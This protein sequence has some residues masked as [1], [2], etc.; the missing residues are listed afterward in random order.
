V[1]YGCG[2]TAPEEWTN[3]DVSPTLRIQK[4]RILKFI[5]RNQL[6]TIFPSNVN[7]GNII[8]GLPIKAETCDA[9]YCSHVLEH[10]SLQD[11][12]IALKNT[13]KILKNGGLFRCVVPDLEFCAREYIKSLENGNNSAGN[14]FIGTNLLL[15]LEKR[16]KGIKELFSSLW[17]NSRHL[18]MWDRKS[19]S[20]ELNNA[21]FSQ[22][23]EC[24]YNDSEDSMFK[25]VENSDR[26]QNSVAF[27]CKK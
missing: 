13:Y 16:P 22:V 5:L 3:F 24:K 25:L 23:R 14:D 6:N 4:I 2:L 21:G 9:V 1:Q 10:L 18:W 27:E 17:G 11:F 26:F 15:G 20:Q 19:F 8:K 7:Y 12:R